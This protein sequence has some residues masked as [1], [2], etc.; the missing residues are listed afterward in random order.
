VVSQQAR[1]R[2]VERRAEK[3]FSRL[4]VGGRGRTWPRRRI[5]SAGDVRPGGLV[6]SRR[7]DGHPPSDRVP[8]KPTR[9]SWGIK[10]VPEISLA[11]AI[12][13][14]AGWIYVGLCALVAPATLALPLTH[15]I[16]WL[17]EDTSGV[18]SFIVSFLGF[19]SYRIS[20]RT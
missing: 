15:L 8:A 3:L 17:R 9:S 7:C 10:V 13:G 4:D 14:M 6:C 2:Q 20:R 19:I 12:Y 11:L 18:L 1:R 5:G 16:P